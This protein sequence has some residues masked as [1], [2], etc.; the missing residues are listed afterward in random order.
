MPKSIVPEGLEGY[1]ED[2]RM[3][4]GLDRHRSGRFR[5]QGS[6]SRT[7]LHRAPSMSAS[8]GDERPAA[9]CIA[10]FGDNSAMFEALQTTHDAERIGFE[11]VD[12]PGFGIDPL[13]HTSLA[14]LAGFV[15]EQCRYQRA[16]TLLVDCFNH[17]IPI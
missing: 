4:P 2:W 17:R 15:L 5:N 6:R 1:I 10:G 11:P 3:S 14:T 16:K 8:I 7:A 9:L 13:P 12:L